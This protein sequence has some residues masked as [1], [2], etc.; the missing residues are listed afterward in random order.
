MSANPHD[1]HNHDHDNHDQHDQPDEHNHDHDN[2]GHDHDGHDHDGHDHDSHDHNQPQG[3]LGWLAAIFH[4]GGHSHS[5]DE[6]NLIAD[7]AF[8]NNEEG[9]RTVWIALALLTL[10][11]LLQVVIYLYSGSVAL[12]A[13]TVHNLGDG[14]NSL[15]LLIAFYLARRPA[16]RRYTYGFHRAE[17]VAGI[18]IV[19]SIM[20]SAGYIFYESINK[21]FNP[22]TITNIGAVAAAAIIG[23]IGNE[24]VATIQIRTGRKIGSAALITDGLHA[25]TDGLTSLAVLIAAG[26]VWIGVPIIDPLIGLTIGVA[27]LFITRDATISVW[28]RLMDAIEPDIYTKAEAIAHDQVKHH[29]GLEEIRRLRM[30]WHGHRLHADLHIAVQPQLTTIEGHE[31]AEQVRLGLFKQLPLLSEILVHVEP[32]SEDPTTYH[33]ATLSRED[34][35]TPIDEE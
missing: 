2:H 3:V 18:I 26:G 7:P 8:K 35:P 20:F 32:W 33:Q 13:D 28:Y 22:N 15:P 6:Q 4:L 30:R 9:I 21:L 27:I 34:V 1:D 14:L 31:L 17:D 5:H 12:L 10:T 19:L 29:E 16:T 25:R 11:T 24:L 23:F